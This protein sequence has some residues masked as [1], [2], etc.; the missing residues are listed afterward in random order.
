[1]ATFQLFFRAKD[2]SAPLYFILRPCVRILPLIIWNGKRMRRI[3]LLSM[4]W[5]VWLYH[6]YNIFPNDIINGMIFGGGSD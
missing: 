4:A 6:I 2:L 5:P 1:M 3:I